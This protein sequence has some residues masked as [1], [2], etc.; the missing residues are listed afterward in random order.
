LNA[1]ERSLRRAVEVGALRCR[2]P[3]PRRLE[4]EADEK[5]YLRRHW[6]LIANLRAAL[7]TEPN[8]RAAVLFGSVARGT[9][10]E[11]SDL[12]LLVELER[13][14]LSGLAALTGRL[15]ERMGR[16][17]QVARLSEARDK[18][19]FLSTILQEG[20]V[21]V[22]R[23]GDWAAISRRRRRIERQAKA[24]RAEA[25]ETARRALTSLGGVQ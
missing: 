22:D 10:T 3:S 14:S 9:E 23:D 1:D 12:D 5:D 20:R 6:P 7:R 18:P 16:E 13:E 24:S 11:A 4:I 15:E 21:I 8:V 17:V 2:R 19:T 25:S